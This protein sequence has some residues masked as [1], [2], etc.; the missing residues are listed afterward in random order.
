[1]VEKKAQELDE[2][3]NWFTPTRAPDA[4]LAG[5]DLP[6]SRPSTSAAGKQRPVT[7][8]P[9]DRARIDHGVDESGLGLQGWLARAVDEPIERQA[10][11]AALVSE[12]FGRFR[13]KCFWKI[14]EDRLLSLLVPLVTR[15]LKRAQARG[16]ARSFGAGGNA[17]A[18]T[19]LQRRVLHVI[20]K[21]ARPTAMSHGVRPSP[22]SRNGGPR[23]STYFMARKSR[24]QGC[25][26][27]WRGTKRSRFRRRSDRPNQLLR[28]RRRLRGDGRDDANSVAQG[29]SGAVF[30]RD[31]GQGVRLSAPRSRSCRQGT[32]C[33]RATGAQGLIRCDQAAPVGAASGDA[34]LGRAGERPGVRAGID[35]GRGQSTFELSCERIAPWLPADAP[36][37]SRRRNCAPC[38]VAVRPSTCDFGATSG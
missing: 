31:R 9:S 16:R 22:A 34:C 13:A 23:T 15:R 4:A 27:R 21:I 28:R 33:G 5:P 20:A 30:P 32:G 18:L 7:F 14:S 25:R 19:P 10:E 8:F 6:P 24:P 37:L 1:V 3:V 17:M 26:G 35:P 11:I 36:R 12:A 29:L 2:N 38:I